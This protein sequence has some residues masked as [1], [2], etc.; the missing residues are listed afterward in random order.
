MAD[1]H[2]TDEQYSTHARSEAP[3]TF[4]EGGLKGE[5]TAAATRFGAELGAIL[6]TYLAAPPPP[7]PPEPEP[8][9]PPTEPEHPWDTG[10]VFPPSYGEFAPF[11]D[12]DFS[13]ATLNRTD[14]T[15]TVGDPRWGVW[16]PPGMGGS[17]DENAANIESAM[18]SP[19]IGGFNAEFF[20]SAQVRTG[21][22]G[23]ALTAVRD[24]RWQGLGYSWMSG[25]IRSRVL[26]TGRG[27]LVRIWAKLARGSGNWSALWLMNGEGDTAEPD[28]CE[29]G[30]M[31]W[32]TGANATTSV[33]ATLHGHGAQQQSR[34]NAGVDLADSFNCFDLVYHAGEDIR[35]FFNGEQRWR[36]AIPNWN[37]DRRFCVMANLSVFASTSNG[38]AHQVNAQ[39]PSPMTMAI[40]RVQFF[41][42]P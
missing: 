42:R 19:A 23:C 35:W 13:A 30:F 9:P 33:A 32:A 14:W 39:T 20:S 3:T 27:G 24:N 4:T 2:L 10:V 15:P 18:Q 21:A 40:R 1:G 6:E 37:T 38:W 31:P 25:I 36:A 29:T 12:D 26:I 17:W 8:P 22:D 11:F 16:K 7:P 41:A 5:V 34:Y 28:I